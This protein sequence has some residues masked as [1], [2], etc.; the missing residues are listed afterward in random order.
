MQANNG[1]LLGGF[2]HESNSFSP[3]PTRSEDFWICDSDNEFHALFSG[4]QEYHGAYEELTAIGYTVYPVI[5]AGATVG[6]VIES[7]VFK[8]YLK[9]LLNRLEQINLSDIVGIQWVLHGSA[10]VDGID[11]VEEQLIEVLKS[12]CGG[13]PIVVSFDLHSTISWDLIRSVDGAVHYRTAPHRDM[14]E[15]G[16][17]ASRLLHQIIEATHPLD[18]MLAKIP[19]LLPGEFGQTDVGVMRNIYQDI[20]NF[21]E[22]SSA[23]DI[24]LSQGFPWADNPEGV[25]SLLGYWAAGQAQHHQ[26]EFRSLA[27]KIWHL[28]NALH[29]SV[30][31]YPLSSI[32]PESSIVVFCDAGDNPTAGGAED[33]TDVLKYVLDKTL[34]GTLFLPIVDPT[35]VQ[36]CNTYPEGSHLPITIGGRLSGTDGISLRAQ[37]VRTGGNEH[38]GQWAVL[39]INDNRVVVTEKRFG[40]SSPDILEDLGFTLDQ[41]PR[42]LVVKSGYLF[43]AWKLWLKQVG[44]EER[45]LSTAGATTLD[46]QSLPYEHILSSTYPL[47]GTENVAQIMRF[48]YMDCNGVQ[49]RMYGLTETDP[50]SGG[51]V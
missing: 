8:R 31:L 50:E 13:L 12:A 9:K 32:K 39:S 24:S 16:R 41:L 10:T 45:L 30:S 11:D 47:K 35:V 23:V 18:R 49:Q 37:I 17:R 3:L 21:R 44:G 42:M 36:L 38:T 51:F 5:A 1:V 20:S 40:V 28:R 7:E 19:L 2:S 25:V 4:D 43:P 14:V 46:L 15:T 26:T 48:W 27:E 29:T 34:K 33:R 6:G 22:S